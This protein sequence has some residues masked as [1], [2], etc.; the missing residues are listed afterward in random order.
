[1]LDN[2]FT[3]AAQQ[4]A[5][6]RAQEIKNSAVAH[7]VKMTEEQEEGTALRVI[8]VKPMANAKMFATLAK[9]IA[10]RATT[11]TVTPRVDMAGCGYVWFGIRRGYTELNGKLLLNAQIWNYLLAFLQGRELPEVTNFEPDRE[12]CCQSEWLVEVAAEVEK[13]TPST[14]EEYN[15]SE[16]GI[17]YLVKKYYLPNGKIVM[18]AETM[19]DI[20]ALLS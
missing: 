19:A 16:E 9:S 1:M 13:L 14:T 6:G 11:L 17:G 7:T 15:E 3:A 5:D 10:A 2:I 20:T 8:K 18:P 4:V 12:I